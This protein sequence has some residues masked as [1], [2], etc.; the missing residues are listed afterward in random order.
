LLWLFWRWGLMNYLSRLASK[1]NPPNLSLPS[2]YDYRCEPLALG[3]LMNSSSLTNS[4]F[5]L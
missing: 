5:L 3:L 1:C 2:N 4:P